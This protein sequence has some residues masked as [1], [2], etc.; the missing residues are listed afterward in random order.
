[1]IFPIAQMKKLG[2]WEGTQHLSPRSLGPVFGLQTPLSFHYV[3]AVAS[4]GE[5]TPLRSRTRPGC[6]SPL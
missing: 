5:Y 4:R 2:L 6:S 1:M 3:T